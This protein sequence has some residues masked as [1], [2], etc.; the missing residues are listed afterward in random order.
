MGATNDLIPPVL[1]ALERPEDGAFAGIEASTDG[2]LLAEALWEL[3]RRGHG[4]RVAR[5]RRVAG[6]LVLGGV[7]VVDLVLLLEALAAAAPAWLHAEGGREDG[8][9]YA[10]WSG[11]LE[12]LL[13]RALAS[14]QDPTPLATLTLPEPLLSSL[15]FSLRRHG[16]DALLPAE[17]LTRIARAFLRRGSPC[18]EQFAGWDR[19]WDREV[20]AR[21]V[22]AEVDGVPEI[23]VK[24]PVLDPLVPFATGK[25]VLAATRKLVWPDR[26]ML[27]WRAAHR[28][29]VTRARKDTEV[30]D[31]L[32]ALPG[33]PEPLP[34][35]ARAMCERPDDE[36]DRMATRLAPVL[37][38]SS[39]VGWD[40]DEALGALGP[41]NFLAVM[42]VTAGRIRDRSE[43]VSALCRRF[44]GH[45]HLPIAAAFWWCDGDLVSVATLL[46]ALGKAALPP[47]L[48]RSDH[49]WL[50]DAA[51]EHLTE[52][53]A[54]HDPVS[55]W[56]RITSAA[57]APSLRQAVVR[58]LAAASK[59]NVA[60]LED[61]LR[62]EIQGP[63]RSLV[64][65]VLAMDPRAELLPAL[66][67]LGERKLPAADRKVLAAAIAG[68][69]AQARYVPSNRRLDLTLLIRLTEPAKAL[70]LA[71]E[72]RVLGAET[73]SEVHLFRG[74][75]H[76][77][78]SRQEGIEC[79]DCVASP[80]GQWL[81]VTEQ[82]DDEDS[83]FAVYRPFESAARIRLLGPVDGEYA[84]ALALSRGRAI[85]VSS[86][87]SGGGAIEA[88][89]LATGDRS[90]HRA[91]GVG[92]YLAAL[93]DERCLIGG[94]DD[95]LI[96]LRSVT[97]GERLQ[98]LP[99]RRTDG[100]GSPLVDLAAGDGGKLV[101]ALD[102]AGWVRIWDLSGARARPKHWDV[103]AGADASGLVADVASPWIA[104]RAPGA[105]KL[106]RGGAPVGLLACAEQ[107]PQVA[108]QQ[109]GVLAVG[110]ERLDVWDLAEGHLGGASHQVV[111][112]AAGSGRLV[113]A[114]PDGTLWEAAA[115]QT[116]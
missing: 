93:D 10:G 14:D 75:Q 63:S 68:A 90:R 71:D 105:V 21:A 18:E 34:A 32:A 49:G 101:A 47:L 112:L 76:V 66:E 23:A 110:G 89:D 92:A 84:G 5:E 24:C 57:A 20:F 38:R 74:E 56:P 100:E 9:G 11:E 22:W 17:A 6:L 94:W 82:D 97:T 39:G 26:M 113:I 85:T 35:L 103:D 44:E 43:A 115:P 108:F 13:R 91:A 46:R 116:K 52:W 99:S 7:A 86:S 72:G 50:S 106:L 15:R 30:E 58:G 95:G 37:G 42:R 70:W 28:D 98:K 31:L 19:V 51:R 60:G 41:S 27:A 83:G 12:R 2:P 61:L 36:I 62:A 107:N 67:A 64:L 109:A 48:L 40:L 77:V 53:M 55:T 79:F 45:E 102:E 104:V 54:G 87:H 25:Q 65:A 114:T 4:A 1:A 59:T 81:L 8:L 29:E 73:K 96:E 88:W 78:I 3:I 80:D 16:V 111:A 33:R 69:K